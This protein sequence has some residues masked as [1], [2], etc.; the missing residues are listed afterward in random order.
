MIPERSGRV[1]AALPVAAPRT[2]TAAATQRAAPIE[3]LS[4]RE[5][6]VLRLLAEGLSNK[7]LA[8]QLFLSVGTVKQHLHHIYGKLGTTSRTSALARARHFGIL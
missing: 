5:L 4:E 2:S 8:T 6:E 1:A 3:P 7:D